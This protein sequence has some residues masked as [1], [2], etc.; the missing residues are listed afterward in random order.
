[1]NTIYKV[2]WNDALRVFQVVN[3]ITRSRKRACSVKSVHTE[4]ASNKL[5]EALRRGTLIAGTTLT[6]LFSTLPAAQAANYTFDPGLVIDLGSQTV[7]GG[8]I[9][10]INASDLPAANEQFIL[11][12]NNFQAGSAI[13]NQDDGFGSSS[14]TIGRI[15][16]SY[17]TGLRDVQI[18]GVTGQNSLIV[19]NDNADLTYGIRVSIREEWDEEGNPYGIVVLQ[20]N[21]TNIQLKDNDTGYSVTLDNDS[22]SND[23]E[24]TINGAGDIHFVHRDD[25]LGGAEGWLTLNSEG[26]EYYGETFVGQ[27]AAT[28]PDGAIHVVFG[29]NEAFG[30]TSNLYV[31]QN[32]EVKFGGMEDNQSYTQDVGGLTGR[33]DLNLGSN[34]IL[35]LKQTTT[36]SGNTDTTDRTIRI[37]NHFVGT[38]NSVFNIDLS[39]QLA[40]TEQASGYEVFFTDQEIFDQSNN[41]FFSSLIT[42]SGGAVTAYNQD[43]SVQNGD[44]TYENVNEILTGATLQLNDNGLLKVEGTGEVHDL[45]I[46]NDASTAIAF[47]DTAFVSG[48]DNPVL[49][50]TGDLVI[51]SSLAGNPTI[52]INSFQSGNQPDTGDVGSFLDADDGIASALIQVQGTVNTNGK[53]FV[54]GGEAIESGTS[55]ITQNGVDVATAHWDFDDVLS[56]NA[57]ADGTGGTFDL[58]YRLLSVDVKDGQ[59]FTLSSDAGGEQDFTA[60]I[61]GSGGLTVDAPGSTVELG[62]AATEE[63]NS[64]TGATTV[65]S[66]TTVVLVEDD[67]MGHTSS[68]DAVGDVTLNDGVHQTVDGLTGTGVITLGDNSVFTLDQSGDASIFNTLAGNGTFAVNGPSTTDTVDVE[69]KTDF[70]FN[71][72]LSFTNANFDLAYTNNQDVAANAHVTLGDGSSLHLGEG[73]STVG[74]LTIASS[75]AKLD[76]VPLVIGSDDPAL[77]MSGTLTLQ[78]DADIALESI[79]VQEDLSLVDY[80]QGSHFQDLITADRGINGS[81]TLTVTDPTELSGLTL[82]YTQRKDGE[83]VTVAKTTWNITGELKP[84]DSSN[85]MQI[86]AEL[87]A[88]NILGDLV[89]SGS[90]NVDLT[91]TVTDSGAGSLT[92][93][94]AESGGNVY[95]TVAGQNDYDVATTVQSGATVS[96][97]T[98]GFG[99]TSLL[100]ID[101]GG[102]VILS[103]NETQTVGGLDGS[104]GLTISNGATFT[105]DQDG[106]AEIDNVLGGSGTFAVDLGA[107]TNAL[108]F[109]NTAST[110]AGTLQVTNALLDYDNTSAM[111]SVMGG[112]GVNLGN[113]GVYHLNENRIAGL[114]LNGGRLV[115]HSTTVSG[116]DDYQL[117]VSGNLNVDS[118]ASSEITAGGVVLGSTSDIFT[119]NSSAG[120]KQVFVEYGG[121]GS[122]T[123]D[124]DGYVQGITLSG[125]DGQSN[126]TNTGSDVVVAHGTWTAGGVQHDETEK[127]LYANLQLVQIELIDESGNGLIL[128]TTDLSSQNELS[129]R[130][131]GSGNLTLAGNMIIGTGDSETTD[132]NDYTGRTQ[133]SGGVISLAETNALGATSVL[134]VTGG[135]VNL[136]NQSVQVGSLDLDVADALTGDGLLYVGLDGQ[137][138]TSDIVGANTGLSADLV[139]RNGHTTTIHDPDG[140]GSG[141]FTLEEGSDLVLDFSS[142]T[143]FD[144]TLSGSG[145]LHVGAEGDSA[146]NANVVIAGSNGDF[147]G[148]IVIE[149]ASQLSATSDTNVDDILGTGVI[150]FDTAGAGLALTQ[151]SG[152]IWLDNALSGAG[153]VSV[154]GGASGQRFGFET[155]DWNGNAFAGTLNLSGLTMTVGGANESGSSAYFA[156]ENAQHLAS[157]NVSLENSAVIEIASGNQTIDT[158]NGLSVGSGSQLVFEGGFGLGDRAGQSQLVLDGALTLSSGANIVVD[159]GAAG[160]DGSFAGNVL[161]SQLLANDTGL[162]VLVDAGEA[163]GNLDGVLLNGSSESGTATQAI[164]ETSGTEQVATGE[165]DYRLAVGADNTQLGIDYTLTDVHIHDQQTLTLSESGTFAAAIHDSG[166]GTGSLSIA[167]NGDITL[168]A[169]NDYAGR[170]TVAGSLTAAAG[171]LGQTEWLHV[172]GTGTYEN[173]GSNTV[174]GLTLDSGASLVLDNRTTLTIDHDDAVES[175]SSVAGAL[176]GSGAI[177]L[178]DGELAVDANEDS[179]WSGQISLGSL[180][181]STLAQLTLNGVDALANGSIVFET[182][183]SVVNINDSG[184]QT[185]TTDVSGFGTINVDLDGGAFTFGTAQNNLAQ[186]SNLNIV[187][188][189]YH[190]TEDNETSFN[191]SLAQNI[192]ITLGADGRLVNDGTA[193]KNVYGLSLTQGGTLDLGV[194][195]SQNGQLVL[196]GEEFSGSG[197]VDLSSDSGNATTVIFTNGEQGD[198]SETGD[199]YV[200]NNAQQLLAGGGLFDLTIIEGVTDLYEGGTQV[201]G[202]KQ[203][204]GLQT[205]SS[206][207]GSSENLYQDADKD[208]TQDELVAV[209]HR[210]G[211]GNFFYDA[212]TDSIYMQYGIRLI[213]LQREQSGEGLSLNAVGLSGNAGTLSAQITGSGNIIFDGGVITVSGAEGNDYTGTTYVSSGA[214]AI[215][216]KDDAFGRTELLDV[217]GTATLN[218]DVS[219]SVGAIAG[220]G[221]IELGDNSHL[222]LDNDLAD[223]ATSEIVVEGIVSGASGAIFTVDGGDE[224][225]D[226]TVEF[227]G[228][229]SLGG[230][231]LEIVNATLGLSGN[232]FNYQTVASA[233]TVLLGNKAGMTVDAAAAGS[234]SDSGYG[235]ND[236]SFSGGRIDFT[237]VT[238]ESA[239]AGS[240]NDAILHVDHLDVSGKGTIGVAAEIDDNFNILVA[241]D[242]NFSQTL[243]Q[244]NT[245]SGR[246]SDLAP[247]VDDMPDSVIAG[248]D[249]EAVAYIQWTGGLEWGANSIGMN[250]SVDELQLSNESSDSEGYVI[251]APV[252]GDNVLTVRITDRDGHEGGAV[253]FDGTMQIGDSNH[254]GA[255]YLN[256]YTGATYV[257]DGTVTLAKNNAFGQ[258]ASLTIYDDGVVN[259]GGQETT[260]GALSTSASGALTGDGLIYVGL[261]DQTGTSDVIGAN[262]GLSADF[263]FRDGHTTTIHDPDGLGTGTFTLEEGSD[264]VLDFSS[265]TAFDNTL[266]GSGTLHVGAEGDSAQNANVVIAGSNGDFDGTIVI[267]NASQLSATSDTNVDDILGT[268]VIAFDTAGAGLALTQAS[269]DIWLDNALSGAGV[270]SVSGGASGQRFGFETADWNG[271]AFA[272]TLNL[273]GLTMTVGGA[274]ESG[275]SAYFAYENAQHLASANVSLENSAVIE[276]ASGNQT[277]D[278]FNGLSVGSG[279]QLVFE[280]GF[281]LG[282]RAG[283]SQLVLDGALTL[284]SGANIVV[285]FGAAGSD[286]SFAGNVLESQL[287]ANDTGL[288]VLVD[289]GEAIGNLDGVLL[290]GSSESG[291]ATQAIYETSGTEQVATGEY[292]YRLAVGADN[293]QLGIDYT[294]TDVHIHDQQTLTLSESGTFAAAIHDSGTGTGSLSIAENGDITLTAQN[295]YAGRTTVAGSLTAAAG[296]LGQTEWLHVSGTGTY[297]NAGSNT[298]GGLTLDS[299]ASLVLDNR[300]TLTIDHDDAVESGSSVAGTVTGAG[301]LDLVNGQLVVDAGVKD[302]GFSGNIT[303]GSAAELHLNSSGLGTGTISLTSDASGASLINLDRDETTTLTN[304]ISGGGII[305]VDLGDSAN[306]FGFADDQAADAFTGSLQLVEGTFDFT[307]DG[308][309]MTQASLVTDAGSIVIVND[310]ANTADRTL[311]GLT[312]GG[313]IVDFGTMNADGTGHITTGQFAN[314]STTDN[315]TTIRVNL[316]ELDEGTGA[317]VFDTGTSVVLVNGYS[318]TVGTDNLV[319]DSTDGNGVN[320]VQTVSQNEVDRANLHYADGTL[321]SDEGTLS[322]QWGLSVIELIDTT[323]G[324]TIDASGESGQ[325]G[326]ITALISGAGNVIFEAGHITIGDEDLGAQAQDANTYTGT[327]TVLDA[328]LTLAKNEALG[329][330]SD[331]IVG[332]GTGQVDFGATQQTFGAMHITKESG[333]TMEGGVITLTSGESL[334]SEV[335]RDVSGEIVL[336]GTGVALELNDAEAVGSAAITMKETGN[337]LILDGIDSSGNYVAFDNLVSGGTVVV[338]QGEDASD[339]SW[340]ELT[341]NGNQ[342][343]LLQVEDGGHVRVQGMQ[344]ASGIELASGGYAELVGTGSWALVGTLDAAVGSELTVSA[345]GGVFNFTSATQNVD[346][347]FVLRDAQMTIGGT[348]G[349]DGAINAVVLAD[350]NATIDAGA[351][352]RIDAQ[353]GAQHLASLTLEANGTADFVDPLDFNGP[354][355]LTVD[356]VFSINGGNILAHVGED[357]SLGDASAINESGL[358]AAEASGAS[359]TLVSAGTI[360]VDEN[361]S[362]DGLL[363]V[364][365]E[366]GKP[367]TTLRTD[368]QSVSGG[369]TDTVAHANYGFD[370][371]VNGT[372]GAGQ[373]LDVGYNLTR[374]DILD[375]KMLTLSEN[376]SLD[377]QI[378]SES[379]DGTLKIADGASIVL[380]NAD[381]EFATAT[382][383]DGVLTATAG[384][385]GNTKW[386]TVSS[387]GDYTNSGNNTVQGLT[388]EDGGHID[389]DAALTIDHNDDASS[390]SGSTIEGSGALNGSG[391]IEL[392][393]GQLT[394]TGANSG[395]SG[396]FGVVTVGTK[397]EGETVGTGATLTINDVNALGNVNGTTAGISL[398]HADSELNVD[399]DTVSGATQYHTLGRTVEGIGTVHVNIGDGTERDEQF[400]SFNNEQVE[401][402][403]TGTISI[404]RGGYSLA[405]V[406]DNEPIETANQ[407]AAAEAKVVVNAGGSLYVST[408][409]HPN[410]RY[411]DKHVGSLELAGGDIYF[412]GLMYNAEAISGE[413]D[414]GQLVLGGDPAVN[415]ADGSLVIS[416]T[417]TVHL[418]DGATNT[419]SADGSEVLLAD[420]GAKIDFI[421]NASSVTV[422]TT[423]LSEVD[424]TM[425]N[426][427]LD[428]ALNLELAYSGSS[429]TISQYIGDGESGTRAVAVVNRIFGDGHGNDIFGIETNGDKS[430]LY[431]N[432]SVSDIELIYAEDDGGLVVTGTSEDD[433]LSARLHGAGN[434]VFR[435]TDSSVITLGKTGTTGDDLN[436]YTG[437][438]RVESGTIKFAADNAFGSSDVIVS[439]GATVNLAGYEQTVPTLNAQ[440]DDALVGDGKYVLGQKEEGLGQES[441]ISGTNTDFTGTIQ[442][443]DGHR[444]TMNQAD[445]LGNGSDVVFTNEDDV[446]TLAGAEGDLLTTL[447]SSGAGSEGTLVLSDESNVNL[448]Q[449]N[450]DYDGQFELGAGTQLSANETDLLDLGQ[451]LGTAGLSVEPDAQLHLTANDDLTLNNALDG[452]GDVYLT[453]NGSDAAFKF[454]AADTASGFTGTYH[455]QGL[456]VHVGGSGDTNSANLAHATTEVMTGAAITVDETGATLGSVDLAG[457]SLNFE[458]A[459]TPGEGEFDGK[460]TVTDNLD[461]SNGGTVSVKVEGDVLANGADTPLTAQD[462]LVADDSAASVELVTA[463]SVS[464]SAG[465]LTLYVNGDE[466]GESYTN[467]I[468][469]TDGSETVAEGTYGYVLKSDTDS[470]DLA[471]GL[472]SINLLQTLTIEGVDGVDGTLSAQLTGSGNF[473]VSGGEITLDNVNNNYTGTTTVHEGAKLSATTHSLGNT[474]LLTVEADATYENLGANKV[475]GIDVAETGNLVLDTNVLTVNGSGSVDGIVSGEGGL[476]VQTGTVTLTHANS[477]AGGTTATSGGTVV[478]T[479]IDALGTGNIEVSSGGSAVFNLTATSGGYVLDNIV[480]GDED[481]I[482]VVNISG[483]SGTAF[484]FNNTDPD[485][486]SDKLFLGT[487]ELNGV[488]ISLAE[489]DVGNRYALVGADVVLGEGTTLHVSDSEVG[490]TNTY[491]FHDRY[492]RGLKLEA[493]SNVEFAG[494]LY[495]LASTIGEGGQLN[496]QN[497]TFDL[498]GLSGTEDGDKVDISLDA[499]ATTRLTDGSELLAADDGAKINLFEGIGNISWN[500]TGSEDLNDYLQLSLDDEDAEQTLRQEVDPDH[501]GLEAVAVI[502][503]VFG[504][505]DGDVFGYETHDGHTD[506]YM[507]YTVSSVNLLYG[508]EGKGLTITNPEEGVQDLTMKITGSGNIVYAGG[509]IDVGYEGINNGVTEYNDYTGATYVREGAEVSLIADNGFGNTKLLDVE[510]GATA[511]FGSFDQ[512][513]QSIAS[514][515]ELRADAGTV[516]TIGASGASGASSVYGPNRDFY[517]DVSLLGEHELVINDGEGLGHGTVT[518]AGN[519]L[520]VSG[521]GLSEAGSDE[522][523]ASIAGNGE[524]Q[525]LNSHLTINQAN[526][527]RGDW[528]VSDDSENVNTEVVFEAENGL[529]IEDVLGSGSSLTVG[530]D[531]TVALNQSTGWELTNDIA[532]SGEIHISAGGNEFSFGDGDYR[533]FDGTFVLTNASF[534]LSNENPN[535]LNAVNNASGL[536]LGDDSTTTVMGSVDLSSPADPTH[537][538][539]DG[540]SV[541]DFGTVSPGKE[542]ADNNL[543]LDSLEITGGTLK[544]EIGEVDLGDSGTKPLTTHDVLLA[545]QGHLIV[546]VIET[547][548]AIEGGVGA[549][550]VDLGNG[551]LSGRDV[552]IVEDGVT[553]ATGTYDFG[554]SLSEDGT[555]VGIAY[556]LKQVDINDGKTLTLTGTNDASATPENTLSATIIGDGDLRIDGGYIKLEAKNDYSGLTTVDEGATLDAMS[557]SLGKNGLEVAGT[558]INAGDNETSYVEVVGSGSLVLNDDSS[559]SDTTD[560]KTSH[561]EV[562]ALGSLVF[563]DDT[564]FTLE[565]KAST[566]DDG[567]VIN[568]N[569]QGGGDLVLSSGFLTVSG[570]NTNYTGDVSVA[571]DATLIAQNVAAVGSGTS[572]DVEGEYRLE[573]IGSDEQS[574]IVRNNFT[575]DGTVSIVGSNV[576]VTGDNAATES[577]SGFTGTFSLEDGTMTVY[578]ATALG[579]ANVIGV[580]TENGHNSLILEFADDTTLSTVISGTADVVKKGAGDLSLNT[581]V[582]SGTFTIESGNVDFTS[583]GADGS[584]STLVMS[585][586]GLTASVAKD[587]FFKDLTIGSNNTFTIGGTNGNAS[588]INVSVA[589]KTNVG[590]GILNVGVNSEDAVAGNVLTTQDFSI[591]GGRINLN[592]VLESSGWTIDHIVVNGTGSGNGSIFVTQLGEGAGGVGTDAWLVQAGEGGNLSDLDLTLV[593]EHGEEDVI[594]AGSYEWHLLEA[595][596]G[597]GYYL[598]AF[599]KGTGDIDGN[600]IREPAAGAQAALLMASQT[601]FDLSLHDHIGNTPY[602]DQLTGEKKL[603]SLWI[604]QRG[605]WSEW[606]DMSGQ[607]STDGKVMT[608]TIGGD[609]KSWVS[610]AGYQ[611]HLGLLGAYAQADFDV[612]SDL[613]NRKAHGEF[614][615]WSVGGY[616]AFQPAGM[617][618]AFGSLQVRW[619]RFDNEAGPSGEAMHEYTSDG[620]SIQGELGYTKTL[621]TFRTFGG[622][623]GYWRIEPHVRAHWNGVSAD[624]TTDDAGRTFSVKGDGNI[625]V[626]VGFRSTLDVTHSVTPTYGDPTVRAYVEANY[627]RNTKQTSVTMTNEFRTSTVEYDNSDMAEFRFGLEGQFNRH[628]NLW[629]DVHHVTGDDAYNSTGVMLGL[630]YNF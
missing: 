487:I 193:D 93:T 554:A 538:T 81:G 363:T 29:M 59:T 439:D 2:I 324:F 421:Q 271:N 626:R 107:S 386:L 46:S 549:M 559:D 252:S 411:I 251:T 232:N 482:F 584:N 283:Q 44:T 624:S 617:D 599:N 10:T 71:G 489:A 350:A 40:A 399:V 544:A 242:Q 502:E 133:I 435:G 323:E 370:L 192:L 473:A 615:G 1:M 333:F 336:S 572:I 118:E 206:F 499:G 183:D 431:L 264:L 176:H 67:A 172:S 54:V 58:V 164:Y 463:G 3:E 62:N 586:S 190:L 65:T 428:D 273:S 430:D 389:L 253:T 354:T 296:A 210:A 32:S 618:G 66:G 227:S 340:V 537:V 165:Y 246:Q 123:L 344:N 306:L 96:I 35:S 555:D 161:E 380:T 485:G 415:N 390:Q 167:E 532:G 291:T 298:V 308:A 369:V 239:G 30:N 5:G 84:S 434:I 620:F 255:D 139:F 518:L 611:V 406:D 275:S 281:G 314:T 424:E 224:L 423:D 79:S 348:A 201:T 458:G 299:G 460:L 21:L 216:A 581:Y 162:E 416:S 422:G 347:D 245:L 566:S 221:L 98:N 307:E 364:T 75:G 523:A 263:I 56:F 8:S 294:L 362:L 119:A 74:S 234:A 78:I 134:Q 269:G 353:T 516:L 593:N 381:N 401:G 466:A 507:N 149:N 398:V 4:D 213:D 571:A 7:I 321:V 143:A 157:A 630:K 608:T 155:A 188:A 543:H 223:V 613:D 550:D 349:P 358:L 286:G 95:F 437:I 413:A 113:G 464:G 243:I 109:T 315:T 43:Y 80:D 565:D 208:G 195:D 529:T 540:D 53:D 87:T 393:N 622:K 186:G 591:D 590:N 158:F 445:G 47:N 292:D 373:T 28:D 152:D 551:G 279:S 346:G 229:S 579:G 170:T 114:T 606:D 168:T 189:A 332:A 522:L 277:I 557:G 521:A 392:L 578:D 414:G 179:D 403:F 402:A 492:V 496:L 511:D 36:A 199:R 408:N 623:T 312:L 548:N 230:T 514:E 310:A 545:D 508:G 366:N 319:L 214:T 345:G 18:V 225:T 357:A 359:Q 610:D 145:T 409:Q 218:A 99:T 503:R 567:S 101:D 233:D 483:G 612:K 395:V 97:V 520:V 112:V 42:L 174:G 27:N 270:V 236:L 391:D 342:F 259:F 471:Y 280:G 301:G 11:N 116:A 169:Q 289:A 605:D 73:G 50:I 262:A 305:R 441:E 63:K 524:V 506:V 261:A 498:S 282:D 419:I 603:T 309:S 128:D 379:A 512:T 573:G 400:F 456:N 444:L 536:V 561:I 51:D 68:L 327:T 248:E 384:A 108:S 135:R 564:T 405:Y 212:D 587:S 446:L 141:I 465:S 136:F 334:V 480:T 244:F 226:V 207:S 574:E 318:G 231:T 184:N 335:N 61:T 48:G 467:V 585:G 378:T 595:E 417:T 339:D 153:V 616:A 607:L 142:T 468:G 272:G 14:I 23:L 388:V 609:V 25:D 181:D 356:G 250:Y 474:S 77:S 138:G 614:T 500:A 131:T 426:K 394:V 197:R 185:F 513:V 302:S 295:D 562:G 488:D 553:V 300:T 539:I 343:A 103:E 338:S 329:D 70:V 517:A 12:I 240:S 462:I 166:T 425:A 322:A 576:T 494:L 129:A 202:D 443:T 284:S 105:L 383:V 351:S 34:A 528:T 258:T 412:G 407:K 328:V 491:D 525:V 222:T 510:S 146:Q 325:S 509:R 217:L 577:S 438:T 442:L 361:V 290:N 570:G 160:S 452:E 330:T 39:G 156:Y 198:V 477:Y 57:D 457:G 257:K 228:T 495:N 455:L 331:L 13:F 505:G 311:A 178:V 625:A 588:P 449:D 459:Y 377:A 447:Q 144:N 472:Q 104:G 450:S 173:A 15:E 387:S 326:A 476:A 111:E 341:N 534:E 127:Q 575:G 124:G 194:I 604:L 49:T 52:E 601:A 372:A 94:P 451:L 38:D 31:N 6:L 602:V 154:S 24:A 490:T 211:N 140:L 461:L 235:L 89:L 563:N 163:I 619:N 484:A 91:A 475:G 560:F 182:R 418:G 533:H 180:G 209:L 583:F 219:Q 241:D 375:G 196:S 191:T 628:L 453:S 368:V 541:V 317:S 33:G 493:G 589:G 515:G 90:G 297:E 598:H 117:F 594:D 360:F 69:F 410:N 220:G 205:D 147:D 126:I 527:F 238:L 371:N 120:I 37:D 55:T 420:D 177:A 558:F 102:S 552:A 592:G 365:N 582:A 547:D 85:S 276:I 531:A 151:A 486:D 352:M 45:T 429:Q 497:G 519:R 436:S 448:V 478:A 86:G 106:D 504:S 320:V 110:F 629:G 249:G 203:L 60:L 237:N 200:D 316:G 427:L 256:D 596:N 433:T 121:S 501:E 313:G 454:A 150:A 267:E 404:D 22:H 288:E 337:S 130:L 82:D 546:T 254:S 530:T 148:T 285:D 187:D 440:G 132:W 382:R 535:N 64:Y 303:L 396:Y 260:V 92:F 100:T 542:V 9:P 268:G 481:A 16:G 367:Q 597:A 627:L 568:G 469:I 88:I 26:N 304:N 397:A 115:A 20:R 287:L 215:L 526:N 470:L 137:T 274:N 41:A 266:S 376:G 19:S 265:T 72:N 293:T 83:S 175:G 159:F 580:A 278:T 17:N 600:E 171:A 125:L 122:V 76:A 374:V 247:A 385:L 621:S 355:Q 204:S 432:Y 569:L 479:N 556:Q